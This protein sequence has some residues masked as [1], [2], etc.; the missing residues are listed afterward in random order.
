MINPTKVF[1]GLILKIGLAIVIWWILGNEE[2]TMFDKLT[3]ILLCFVLW[4][5]L[6]IES[7]MPD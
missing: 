6:D 5:L 4:G 3:P 1:G 7:K 2:V